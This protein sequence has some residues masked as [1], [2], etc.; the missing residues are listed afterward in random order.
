MATKTNAQYLRHILDTLGNLMGANNY[1]ESIEWLDAL[2]KE[3]SDAKEDGKTAAERV[4]DLEADVDTQQ[5]RITE[6]A[7]QLEEFKTGEGLANK[8]DT[9]MGENDTLLWDCGNIAIQGLMET[10]GEKLQKHGH[11]KMQS[12]I[13]CLT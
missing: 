6:L 13:N 2:E 12:F 3:L 1:K 8:I 9:Y 5:E 10:F 4:G 11:I 7:G